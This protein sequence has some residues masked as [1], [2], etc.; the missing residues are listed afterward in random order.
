M[1]KQGG[2]CHDFMSDAVFHSLALC[3]RA[4]Q[5][6]EPIKQLCVFV[7][8]TIYSVSDNDL[9]DDKVACIAKPVLMFLKHLPCKSTSGL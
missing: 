3:H 4:G 9:I 2:F 5:F 8:N 7:S 1:Q 6:R